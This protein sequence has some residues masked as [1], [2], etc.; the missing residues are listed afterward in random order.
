MSYLIVTAEDPAGSTLLFEIDD[1]K[2]VRQLKGTIAKNI[3]TPNKLLTCHIKRDGKENT[4]LEDDKL[5]N[6]YEI[7]DS[8]IIYYDYI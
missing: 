2:T 6:Y 7:T 1:E 3:G 5:I 4:P 8:D